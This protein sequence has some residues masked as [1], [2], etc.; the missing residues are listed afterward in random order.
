MCAVRSDGWVTTAYEIILL[1]FGV[2]LKH[3][4][5]FA[6]GIFAKSV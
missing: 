6:L 5:V 3:I 2:G 4:F 1:A